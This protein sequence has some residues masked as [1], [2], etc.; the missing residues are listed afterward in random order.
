MHW[1]SRTTSFGVCFLVG[2]LVAFIYAALFGLPSR[3][4]D[5]AK[6]ITAPCAEAENLNPEKVLADLKSVEVSTRHQ[7]FRRLFLNPTT[8]SIYYDYERDLKYPERADRARLEYV[9]LDDSPEEEALLTFVRFEHP[10]ALVFKRESCGWKLAGALSSWLR[11][12]DYPYMNWLS[13]PE[14]IKPG[15]HE[16]LVRESSG[17]SAAY[18]RKVLLLRLEHDALKQM[19]EID[20]EELEPVNG[21]NGADWS[22]TKRRRTTRFN[23]VPERETQP[24]RIELEVTEEIVHLVDSPPIHN[25]WMEIDGSWHSQPGYWSER[26]HRREKLLGVSRSQL[27]WNKQ[28]ARFVRL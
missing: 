11:F 21:Y 12:E 1:K 19:A 10:V 7:M 28:E 23:F 20:E 15:V 2:L 26:P 4:F 25:Y 9:Q 8:T 13:L 16:L 27:V 6:R 24:A 17:D 3:R 5:S 18:R 22:D 14:T